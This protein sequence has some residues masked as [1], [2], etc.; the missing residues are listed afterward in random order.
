MN[1]QVKKLLFSISLLLAPAFMITANAQ[2]SSERFRSMKSSWEYDKKIAVNELMQF[3]E[4][5]ANQFWPV[6][7]KYMK[8]WGKLMNYRITTMEQYC[9]EIENI[10]SD[11]MSQLMNQLFVNDV[12][13]SKLQKKTYKKV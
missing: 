2:I 1:F 8:E 6:Y 3:N 12:D 11:R 5:E 13:L 4:K 7:N 9:E 10:K